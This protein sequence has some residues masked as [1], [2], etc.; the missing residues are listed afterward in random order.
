MDELDLEALD[1]A[2]AW[3]AEG[4]RRAVDRLGHEV[5]HPLVLL[6]MVNGILDIKIDLDKLEA[7][8]Q[9][10]MAYRALRSRLQSA[11]SSDGLGLGSW[12]TVYRLL[13]RPIEAAELAPAEA[14][15]EVL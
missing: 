2:R 15:P 9:L 10:G 6:D 1:N 4:V 5:V 8:T 7:A 12:E 11:I 3:H 13:D 14:P